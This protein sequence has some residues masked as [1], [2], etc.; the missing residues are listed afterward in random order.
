MKR[1]LQPVFTRFK[2]WFAKKPT[3]VGFLVT[4]LVFA[5][6]VVG[7]LVYQ[8]STLSRTPRTL[9][10]PAESKTLT[11]VSMN[12]SGQVFAPRQITFVMSDP[13]D[14]HQF[15]HHLFLSPATPGAVTQGRS[16]QQLVFTPSVPFPDGALISVKIGKELVSKNNKPLLNDYT[17]S[18]QTG[19]TSDA[20]HFV[21]DG[22]ALRLLT[23]PKD[24]PLTFSL[25]Y[26]T[27]V[28]DVSVS[29]YRSNIEN[30]LN[31]M[32]Y[33]SVSKTSG[34]YTYTEEGYL[35]HAITHQQSDLVRTFAPAMEKEYSATVPPGIYYLEAMDG[36]RETVSGAFAVIN[37]IGATLRQDDRVVT[38]AAFDLTTSQGISDNLDV[39]FYGLDDAPVALTRGTLSGV[40]S[41]SLPFPKRLDLVLVSRGDERLVVPVKLPQSQ[42]DLNVTSNLDEDGRIFLYTDRPIY[43]PGD[44]VKFRGIVR[45]D[46]DSLYQLPQS[47]SQVKV[48]LNSSSLSN[49]TVFAQVD[50]HGIFSGQ[51]PLP[52]KANDLQYLYAST[53]LELGD[54]FWGKTYGSTYFD[55]A[56]YTKPEFELEAQVDKSESLKHEPLTF[57]LSGKF[58]DGRPLSGQT[59]DYKFYTQNFYETERAAYN[60]NFNITAWGGMCGG[61]FSPF[62]E[63]YGLEVPGGGTV[64]LDARGQATVS[65]RQKDEKSFLSQKVAVVAKK[66]DNVGN[67]IVASAIAIVHAADTNIFFIPS[68]DRYSPDE[69]IVAPFYAETL[70]GTKLADTEFSY[71]LVSSTYTYNAAGTSSIDM[72]LSSGTAKTDSTGRGIAKLPFPKEP[73]VNASLQLIVE[74]ADGYGNLAQNRKPLYFEP[75]AQKQAPKNYWDRASVSQTYLKIV[76]SDSS[77]TVGEEITLTINSPKEMDV[78]MSL[79]RGRV[80]Q[81]R[82]LH[83]VRGDNTVVI[84]VTASLS[85]SITPVFSFFAD[86]LYHS[87]GLS[88]NVP[89]LHQLMTVEV[90]PDKVRY[91]PN[92]TATIK[93]ATREP[94][95]AP[96]AAQFSLSVVDKAIFALRKNATPPIHSSFYYFRP[97]RTNASSSLTWIGQFLGGGGGGGGGG[98]DLL[99]KPIDTLYWNP[100]LSTDTNGEAIVPVALNNQTTTWKTQVYA[101]TDTSLVGQDDAEFQV[102]P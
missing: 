86:G 84:P 83:L 78:L 97:R 56:R 24:V 76:S 30:L 36:N 22:F 49:I 50:E 92:D 82:K 39:S 3:T 77:Y 94:N 38:L 1:L 69:E 18:F 55:V 102:A 11:I 57:T 53:N 15:E 7:A 33:G 32:V 100:R 72:L 6:S 87:E 62:D 16:E 47:N 58:F 85:P 25:D 61:G 63:N 91:T 81:P 75:P 41:F 101:S 80:Y 10:P 51:F 95:G 35:R 79:E 90:T 68:G 4:L 40:T 52:E 48:W 21:K 65:F 43:K 23:L 59:V 44:P 70:T 37:T 88:L 98:G 13:V 67:E 19:L 28:K 20:I 46:S 29:L 14:L 73:P 26:P 2:Q 64:T 12:P 9:P 34:S 71:R 96:V 17:N 42:A 27:H 60:S 8:Y 45:K 31:F 89:A 99:G 74:K 93:V 54:D 66:K 5:L